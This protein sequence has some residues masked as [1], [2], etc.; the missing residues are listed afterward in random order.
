MSITVGDIRELLGE[1][2]GIRAH[3]NFLARLQK[4]LS[5]QDIQAREKI[6]AYHCGLHD[7]KDEIQFHIDV[8]KR[9][10]RELPKDISLN[11]PIEEHEEIQNLYNELIELTD[12]AAIDRFN[13]QELGEFIEKI[14][15][16][17]NKIFDLVEIHITSENKILEKALEKFCAATN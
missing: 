12:S 4:N 7:F 11:A 5:V 8:D 6:W 2:E 3:M 10:F 9:I 13:E 14:K 16:A 1:H 17:I 15:L